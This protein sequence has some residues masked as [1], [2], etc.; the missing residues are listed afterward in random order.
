MPPARENAPG[1]ILSSA[2]M[3][4]RSFPGNPIQFGGICV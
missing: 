2:V 1:G 4:M 3:R